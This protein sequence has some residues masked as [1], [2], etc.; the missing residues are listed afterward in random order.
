MWCS[1]MTYQKINSFIDSKGAMN[2]FKE[3]FPL[4]RMLPL[5]AIYTPSPHLKMNPQKAHPDWG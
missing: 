1:A 5:A 2:S 4:A 3:T